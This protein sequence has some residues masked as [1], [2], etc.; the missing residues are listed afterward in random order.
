MRNQKPYNVLDIF[1]G[2]FG[3]G[4]E[5]AEEKRAREDR[6]EEETLLIGFSFR[7]HDFEGSGRC[8]TRIGQ[9]VR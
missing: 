3:P 4:V 6:R 2:A 8:G 5:K 1:G 7:P 9:R